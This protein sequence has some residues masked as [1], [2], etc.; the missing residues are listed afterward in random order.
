MNYLTQEEHSFFRNCLSTIYRFPG[1]VEQLSGTLFE[2]IFAEM[3]N[4]VRQNGGSS[5]AVDVIDSNGI[6]YSLKTA[7]LDTSLDLEKILGIKDMLIPMTTLTKDKILSTEDI[8][9]IIVPYYNNL[10]NLI[11]KQGFL[12]RLTSNPKES[13]SEFRFL[14]WEHPFESINNDIEVILNENSKKCHGFKSD[15]NLISIPKKI[16][17]NSASQRLRVYYKIPKNA[18]IIIINKSEKFDWKSLVEKLK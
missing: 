12:I 3:K 2:D 7:S 10:N 11:D 5:N 9:N 4:G 15:I 1:N 14:Y 18:D 17:W 16:T 13:H 8:K 6:K